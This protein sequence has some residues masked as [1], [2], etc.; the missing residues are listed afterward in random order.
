MDEISE[1]LEPETLAE[2]DLVCIGGGLPAKYKNI[3]DR[4]ITYVLDKIKEFKDFMKQHYDAELI[5]EPGR[6]LSA[7]PVKLEANIIG[8]HDNNIIV[9]A[10]VYN[11]DTDSVFS[12]HLR[13]LVEDE[14]DEGERYVIKGMTPCSLD[15]F[16]YDVKLAKKPEVGD[17]IIFLNAGAYN[18]YTEFCSLDKIKTEIV[19]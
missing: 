9:D 15:I 8:I 12:S 16:R 13:L 11:S 18:F 14:L 17:K 3:S 6:F 7:S 10:S 5:V 1:T 2:L 19:D 4:A